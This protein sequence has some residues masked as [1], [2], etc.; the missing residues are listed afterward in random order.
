MKCKQYLSIIKT[1]SYIYLTIWLNALIVALIL[2]AHN[3]SRSF[4]TLA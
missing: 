4:K 2:L 1:R 3:K